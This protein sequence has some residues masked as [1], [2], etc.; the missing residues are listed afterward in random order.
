MREQD[1]WDKRSDNML[2][3]TCVYFIKKGG[4]QSTLGRCR[5]RALTINGFPP[6]FLTDWCGDHKLD[7]E[8][9]ILQESIGTLGGTGSLESSRLEV[10]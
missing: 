9:I 4:P 5:R 3:K 1:N 8:K 7:E 6:V 2:C 10:N